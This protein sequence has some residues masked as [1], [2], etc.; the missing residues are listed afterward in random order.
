[1]KTKIL[2]LVLT[3]V[4]LLG[5]IPF[6]ISADEPA[7]PYTAELTL[8]GEFNTQTTQAVAIDM[9]REITSSETDNISRIGT[10]NASGL[11]LYNGSNWYSLERL[12]KR[13]DPSL[14]Y[15]IGLEL[16][17]TDFDFLP[18]YVNAD[19]TSILGLFI[20]GTRVDLSQ[21]G[22]THIIRNRWTNNNFQILLPISAFG[23]IVGAP[24]VNSVAVSTATASVQ[25]GTSCT[26][27]ATA[28][29]INGASNE[30]TWAFHKDCVPTDPNTTIAGGVLTVGAEET[31]T[32]ITLTVTSVF[33]ST[34]HTDIRVFV[35]DE[36]PVFQFYEF[37]PS[38][39]TAYLGETTDRIRLS[40]SG[41]ERDYRTVFTLE[42][43]TAAGTQISAMTN[44][45]NGY[46]PYVSVQIDP[47]ETAEVLTLVAQSVAHP[48]S[49]ATLTIQVKKDARFTG[50]T[51][52]LGTDLA[53]NYYVNANDIDA[54]RMAVQFT[55]N[56]VTTLVKEYT[57][58]NGQYVF[59]FDQIA[60]NAI[61]DMI[62]AS[63]VILADD[64][65]TVERLVDEKKQYSVATY[66]TDVA[67]STDN[68][69]VLDLLRD[70]VFY[71][72]K[73]EQYVD[74]TSYINQ[75]FSESFTASDLLPTESDNAFSLDNSLT[76]GSRLTA[77][78]VFFSSDNKIYV[79]INAEE[80][81]KLVIKKNGTTIREV[82]FAQGTYTYYTDG[83]LSTEFDN[84]Y[85]FELYSGESTTALQTLTYS[86]NTYA[87]RMQ[88]HEDESGE[89]S[90]M[91][92]LARALYRYG[93]SAEAFIAD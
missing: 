86:V 54:N 6:S 84:V 27:T 24:A 3:A 14:D 77:A 58:V 4:M 50:A 30:L 43:A 37:N 22:T 2:S 93:K 28:D 10:G 66:I 47:N 75:A 71:C 52:T 5:V 33:D 69:K 17:T 70:L 46:I 11:Y 41:T 51:L 79:K 82:A 73:A 23:G 83:I 44:G 20:N 89:I 59:Q 56:E 87:Y 68:K 1:M 67:K 34:K 80:T 7:Y 26:F 65:T 29:A 61:L 76:S 78:G 8:N 32:N 92:E 64:G 74:G 40:I 85:T 81:V 88:N 25:K 90:R 63:L 62:D 21:P 31:L 18:E 57:I 12:S 16:Y 13:L 35:V 72:D 9:I 45:S 15:M 38:R 36:A 60:P 49:T 42:G 55:V 39:I 91:A 48:E 19:L 53:L